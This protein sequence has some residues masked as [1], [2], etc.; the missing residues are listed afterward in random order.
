MQEDAGLGVESATVLGSLENRREPAPEALNR[1]DR[2]IDHRLDGL[3]APFD[4]LARREIDA[5]VPSAR[6]E[7]RGS[8]NL[9]DRAQDH[10]G[11]P[12]RLRYSRPTPNIDCTTIRSRPP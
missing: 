10:D 5:F 11:A 6:I 3:P 1:R 12:A 7:N 2:A 8:V 4:G 9:R